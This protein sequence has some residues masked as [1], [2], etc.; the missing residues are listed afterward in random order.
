MTADIQVGLP[1]EIADIIRSQIGAFRRRHGDP[2]D[3]GFWRL[4]VAASPDDDVAESFSEL[5]ASTIEQQRAADLDSLERGLDE[6]SIDAATAHAW[7]R[8]LNQLRLVA[9]TDLAV[10]DDD[11]WRPAPGQDGFAQAV[12]YDLL[13]QLQGSLIDAVSE[14]EGL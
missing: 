6:T 11:S 7:I 14:A 4:R 1:S 2:H 3:D 5:T 13:T 8:A 9:G 10:T 12:V